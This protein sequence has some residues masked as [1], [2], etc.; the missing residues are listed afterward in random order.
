[1]QLRILS[2]KLARDAASSL[3]LSLHCRAPFCSQLSALHAFS[4]KP[5]RDRGACVNGRSRAGR[6]RKRER[7][8]RALRE[9]KNVKNLVER[10]KEL[11]CSSCSD[12]S[13]WPFFFWLHRELFRPPLFSF[14]LLHFSP[15]R[16]RRSLFVASQFGREK[17]SAERRESHSFP[18]LLTSLP[19]STS[20]SQLSSLQ[21]SPFP[22]PPKKHKK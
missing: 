22:P 17:Y 1:M 18:H 11:V 8:Q 9:R 13:L 12:P 4:K 20:T 19:T 16:K 3:L 10:K 2:C 14:P 15:A 21:P 5:A 6:K 7:S